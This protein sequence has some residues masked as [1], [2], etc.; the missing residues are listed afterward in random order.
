MQLDGLI[1]TAETARRLKCARSTVTRMVKADRLKPAE[2]IPGYRG[3][4]LFD[5]EYIDAIAADSEVAA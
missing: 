3:D 2:V 1:G 4:L 5:P